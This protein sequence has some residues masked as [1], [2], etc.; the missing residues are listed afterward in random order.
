[1][2][3]GSKD[4]DH[5]FLKSGEALWLD[6]PEQSLTDAELG[7]VM[8]HFS[9][10]DNFNDPQLPRSIKWQFQSFV[11]MAMNEGYRERGGKLEK[12]SK[13]STIVEREMEQLTKAGAKFYEKFAGLDPV[14]KNWLRQ[15]SKVDGVEYDSIGRDRFRDL[16]DR[17]FGLVKDLVLTARSADG[18]TSRGP[19]NLALREMVDWLAG[20]WEICHGMPPTTDKGR[21]RR[22]EAF[23]ELCQDVAKIAH[24][25]LKAKG[26]G[27]TTLKL[28]F[29]VDEVIKNRA[30]ETAKKP[31]EK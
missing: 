11:V 30:A 21:G 31:R 6:D 2:A 18:I 26:G 8:E 24:A 20:C 28:P 7:R 14:T 10:S 17:L 9:A 4:P 19:N 25:K 5:D 3:D 15:L 16:D 27:L 1:M 12:V 13:P 22:D 29:I 23:L